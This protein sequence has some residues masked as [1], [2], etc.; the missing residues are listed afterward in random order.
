M[1]EI[2]HRSGNSSCIIKRFKRDSWYSS[3]PER[4]LEMMFIS[5]KVRKHRK[6]FQHGVL[7]HNLLYL[8][9]Q[10]KV[11]SHNSLGSGHISA[12]TC[13]IHMR[14]LLVLS[15][16]TSFYHPFTAFIALFIDFVQLGGCWI[17]KMWT[18]HR[19]HGNVP[20]NSISGRPSTTA[21]RLAAYFIDSDGV[22]R[23]NSTEIIVLNSS[24]SHKSHTKCF[25]KWLLPKHFQTKV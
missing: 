22:P 14:S 13:G 3:R 9:S 6:Q 8:Q 24:S 1:G 12:P 4:Y 25:P 2:Q 18:G 10:S 15:T 16:F 21:K 7:R 20:P 11:S 5:P 23:E 19:W 17:N